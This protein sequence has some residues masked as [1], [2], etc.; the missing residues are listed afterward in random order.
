VSQIGGSGT[1]LM[2]D[3]DADDRMLVRDAL[4]DCG[5]T[6]PL[7]FVEDGEALLAYLRRL[8]PYAEP[9]RAPRPSLI[10]LDLNMPKKDGREALKEIKDDPHLADI[11]V[12]VLTTSTAAKDTERSYELGASSVVVKPVTYAGLVL[13][14]QGVLDDWLTAPAQSD[15]AGEEQA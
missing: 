15:A 4:A 7:L 14:I 3:D 12:V 1:I 13:L 11:P 2:A 9:G 6:N 10:L 8:G 5:A